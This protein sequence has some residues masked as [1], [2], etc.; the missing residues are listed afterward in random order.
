[1][2]VKVRMKEDELIRGAAEESFEGVI[3][4]SVEIA[5]GVFVIEQHALN[6]LRVRSMSHRASAVAILP[7]SADTFVLAMY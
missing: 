7:E 5:K 6:A 4:V 2:K 1:M 3:Q